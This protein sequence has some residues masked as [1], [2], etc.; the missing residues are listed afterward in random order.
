MLNYPFDTRLKINANNC[1]CDKTVTVTV[2][3]IH[4]SSALSSGGVKCDSDSFDLESSFYS[5][6]LPE[7]KQ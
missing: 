4:R 7:R 5:P 3:L 2:Q 1:V 6:N